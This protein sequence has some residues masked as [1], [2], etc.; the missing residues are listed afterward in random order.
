[1]VAAFHQDGFI[2]QIN[3]A[4][5]DLV[6]AG[7]VLGRLQ[8]DEVVSQLS[9][10]KALFLALRQQKQVLEQAALDARRNDATDAVVA[11]LEQRRDRAIQEM[12]AQFEVVDGLRE[13]LDQ[14]DLTLAK[15]GFVESINKNVH[16]LAKAGEPVIVIKPQDNFYLFNKSLAVFS[17]LAF[18][19]FLGI[20]FMAR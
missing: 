8:T 20:H 19:I 14:M 7:Q 4:E 5:G 2:A 3:A 17:C 9:R 13:K 1:M 12:D 11:D 10:E 15:D 18:F 16:D 6:R